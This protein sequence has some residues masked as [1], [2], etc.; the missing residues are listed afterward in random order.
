MRVDTN[1]TII[2]SSIQPLNDTLRSQQS[3]IRESA[4]NTEQNSIDTQPISEETD[5]REKGVIR[6]LREGHFKGV[7][8]VRLRINFHDDINALE[9]EQMARVVQEKVPALADSV[10]SDLEGLL[11][12]PGLDEQFPDEIENL[13]KEF[14]TN[15]SQVLDSFLTTETPSKDNLI[16]QLQSSFDEF[17]A[18]LKSSFDEAV[19][20]TAEELTDSIIPDNNENNTDADTAPVEDIAES[21]VDTPQMLFEQFLA[22]LVDSFTTG[23]DELETSLDNTSV[24]PDISLP[25]GNGRAYDKFLAAYYELKGDTPTKTD[26]QAINTLT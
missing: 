10:R 6:L 23:L 26:P 8:D 21:G 25:H 11:Q 19:A 22:K 14:D 5:N 13:T 18:G 16:S 12:I 2:Q 3:E 24:L 9:Q 1:A 15:M 7:A 17:K 20:A 4:V